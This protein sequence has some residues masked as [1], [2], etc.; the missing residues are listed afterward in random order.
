MAR[1]DQSQFLGSGPEQLAPNQLLDDLFASSGV[2]KIT[3]FGKT[4]GYDLTKA[5]ESALGL[6][7][8]GS[9]W[10]NNT[11][12]D[13]D[14]MLRWLN[15]ANVMG[16]EANYLKGGGTSKHADN[17]ANPYM[18]GW[19]GMGQLDPLHDWLN[20]LSYGG[21]EAGNQW[22]GFRSKS[23]DIPGMWYN[24][25]DLRY[26]E[27]PQGSGLW[28]QEEWDDWARGEGASSLWDLASRS[29][30]LIEGQNEW[31]SNP[32]MWFDPSNPTNPMT[33][34]GEGSG[35][36]SELG[37]LRME[38]FGAALA[39]WNNRQ[40]SMG[41][42]GPGMFMDYATRND[43]QFAQ[44][45]LGRYHGGYMPMQ[46]QMNQ[47]MAG[48]APQQADY[49]Y[50]YQSAMQPQIMLGQLQQYLNQSGMNF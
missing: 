34:L 9:M 7:D 35:L 45:A 21:H 37:A 20:G 27:L 14:S 38:D 8:W 11:L 15:V 40:T 12:S 19:H 47:L 28:G 10:D 22:H 49:S 18:S 31:A 36:G 29:D 44:S 46:G 1:F 50:L 16:P 13:P 41:A 30:A 48:Y 25:E 2:N 5:G 33:T 17:S 26:T 6:A 32:G 4:K 3:G 43:P 42:M 24:P 39:D 23:G